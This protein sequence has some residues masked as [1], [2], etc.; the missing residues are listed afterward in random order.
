MWILLAKANPPFFVPQPAG[1]SGA[2]ILDETQV[3]RES[4]A[5]LVTQLNINVSLRIISAEDSSAPTVQV[6]RVVLLEA[7]VSAGARSSLELASSQLKF[8]VIST[9]VDSNTPS[10]TWIGKQCAL[11]RSHPEHVRLQML[12]D[13]AHPN[14]I[15]FYYFN[16]NRVRVFQ[17]QRLCVFTFLGRLA[18]GL[19]VRI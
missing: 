15:L 7:V 9:N 10:A 4:L 1:R 8:S 17:S 12:R 13:V 5:K 14:F 11:L 18:S 16:S 6:G 3:P 2:V 19:C